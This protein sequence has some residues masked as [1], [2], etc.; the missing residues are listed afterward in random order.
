MQRMP[1]EKRVSDIMSAARAVLAERGVQEAFISE[2]AERA[3]VVEG[4]IYRFFASKRELLEKLA[5]QWYEEAL[6]DYSAQLAGVRGTWNRLRFIV[7]HHLVNVKKHPAL[8]RLVLQEFRPSGDYRST[9]LFELNQVYSQRVVEVVKA[10][11]RDG[12]FRAD[13]SPGFV[14][15][16]IF[17]GIEHRI[18]AFLRSEGDFDA[19]RT[20][21]AVTDFVWRALG[22]A[23]AE[24]VDRV[25]AALS[26]IEA[27][28]DRLEELAPAGTAGGVGGKPGVKS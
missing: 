3:G 11:V 25:A 27:V 28:A 7:Y 21:D 17:G 4:S 18:W 20:A 8:S 13:F 22:A 9:R 24:P 16:M 5:E 2:V 12:E 1:A 26:R 23:D 14:R 6:A 15:D 10:A 19:S